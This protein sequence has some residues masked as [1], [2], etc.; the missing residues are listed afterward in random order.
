MNLV[1]GDRLVVAIALGGA[2]PI[3]KREKSAIAIMR[4]FAHHVPP[5]EELTLTRSVSGGL[6]GRKAPSPNPVSTAT[7][8]N[9]HLVSCELR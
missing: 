7:D 4:G 5:A 3:A 1:I 2:L 6:S 9:H 8:Y